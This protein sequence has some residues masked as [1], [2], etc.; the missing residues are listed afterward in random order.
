M[1]E[2]GRRGRQ[3]VEEKAKKADQGNMEEK[4]K[5]ADRG[6]ME[7]K[8]DRGNLEEKADKA[9]RGNLEEKE[10]TEKEK[11][12]RRQLLEEKAAKLTN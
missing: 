9:E 8:A 11:I 1:T 5:K 4:A 12:G 7:E 10:R 2:E 3:L 6:N